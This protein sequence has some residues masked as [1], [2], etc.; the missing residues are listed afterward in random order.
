MAVHI[1]DFN[2]SQGAHPYD[3]AR[4]VFANLKDGN[5]WCV[6]FKGKLHGPVNPKDF[7]ESIVNQADRMVLWQIQEFLEGKREEGLETYFDLISDQVQRVLD[8]Q[9]KGS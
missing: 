6:I 7:E 2:M 3:T 1:C 8:D 5:D 9:Q 4:L